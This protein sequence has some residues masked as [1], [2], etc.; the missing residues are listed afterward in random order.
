MKLSKLNASLHTQALAILQKERLTFED[1][2]FVLANYQESANHLIAPA[3]AF[4]TSAE[5][6]WEFSVVAVGFLSEKRKFRVLDLCAG[7]G[8]LAHACLLRNPDI[9]LVCVDINADYV[10]VGKKIVPQ[11]QWHCMDALDLDQLKALGHFDIVIS[12]PPFG[13]VTTGSGKKSPRYTGSEFA[14]KAIDIAAEI[15][16]VG[17]FILPQK[18]VPFNI[19]ASPR[20]EP[21][22]HRDAYV[23]FLKQ[24]RWELEIALTI[25]TASTET[26]NFKNTRLTVEFAECKFSEIIAGTA[27][28]NAA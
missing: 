10:D 25:D 28:S 20:N 24:T 5:L 19:S 21:F 11:A 12:N 1:K 8:A 22:V 7:I 27:E 14:Y 16:D 6:A 4:F 23:K 18:L 17:Y 15:A 9:E 26:P 3:G 2:E 13:A